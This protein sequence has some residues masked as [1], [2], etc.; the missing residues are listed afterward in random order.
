MWG[1][2]L[3]LEFNQGEKTFGVGIKKLFR[4][5]IFSLL[6]KTDLHAIV[7]ISYEV[8]SDLLTLV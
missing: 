2:W 1:G 3:N 8:K 7:N 5:Y 6:D 4:G